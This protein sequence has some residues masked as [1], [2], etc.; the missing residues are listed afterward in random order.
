[1]LII[2]KEKMEEREMKNGMVRIDTK[3]YEFSHGSQP[4]GRGNWLF[5]DKRHPENEMDAEVLI[6]T[7]GFTRYSEA[8][9]YAQRMAAAQ[10]IKR[11]YVLP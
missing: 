7:G 4:K 2:S 3:D 1:M 10:D 8:K 9:N 5:C 6:S 11:L